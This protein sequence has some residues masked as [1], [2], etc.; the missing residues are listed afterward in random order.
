[1]N[2]RVLRVSLVRK[3]G[4]L[5]AV[6]ALFS[7]TLTFSVASAAGDWNGAQQRAE[8]FKSE[9]EA[10]RTLTPEH[11]RRLVA[12]ICA[13]DKGERASVAQDAAANASSAVSA[14]Y[15][16]LKKLK[17]ETFGMLEEVLSD[18]AQKDKHSDARS[19]RDQTQKR[20]ETIERMTQSIRGKNHPVVRYMIEQ[21]NRMHEERQK[22]CSI[23]E[24]TMA[25]GRADCIEAVPCT[26]V[27][28]KPDNPRAIAAGKTQVKRYADELNTSAQAR[29]KLIAEKGEFAKCTTFN[30]R[31]DCY[32]QC[33]E[34]DNDSNDMKYNSSGWRENCN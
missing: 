17:D 34:I 32:N 28:L 19:W 31:I 29:Q 25:S 18:P 11:T 7:S 9:Y 23:K 3:I 8:K 20:W 2:N 4:T 30:A 15:E 26:V 5:L 12:A 6:G 22:A 13:A 33:P 1:M 27:E 16:E 21:G 24:F 14:K 10:L